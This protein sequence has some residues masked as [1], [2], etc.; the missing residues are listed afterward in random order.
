[1]NLSKTLKIGNTIAF[2]HQEE[3]PLNGEN[4]E[5]GGPIQLAI[6]APPFL[7]IYAADGGYYEFGSTAE[8]NFG[9]EN[10]VTKALRATN[11]NNRNR[12]TTTFYAE[13]EPVKGLR[14]RS[15]VGADLQFNQNDQYSLSLLGSAKYTTQNAGA[16][17]ASNYNPSYL[18]ENTATYSHIF[19]EKHNL[20]FLLGQSTQQF[21]YFYLNGS[22]TGYQTNTLRL[23]DAGPINAQI[24]NGGGNG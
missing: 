12:V 14:L 3:H 11:K 21:D 1:M 24:A 23:L 4:D 22:R 16:S 2:S 18:I 20:T 13:L 17:S 6:Q 15:S 10:P 8:D 9:E 7:P 19:A 5:F